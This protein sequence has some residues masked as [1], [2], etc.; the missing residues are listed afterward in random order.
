MGHVSGH[1]SHMVGWHTDCSAQSEWKWKNSEVR[2][3]YMLPSKKPISCFHFTAL[4]KFVVS[5]IYCQSLNF[6]WKNKVTFM[7]IRTSLNPF[8]LFN[9]VLVWSNLCST[10]G[11]SYKEQK[12]GIWS[13]V[14]MEISVSR[15]ENGGN[16]S[17]SLP[18][19]LFLSRP[20][21]HNSLYITSL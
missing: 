12:A 20:Y 3:P 8:N 13:I 14:C 19:R 6:L 15:K 16:I 9:D 5:R 21:K 17:I 2:C 1:Q 18:W 7:E 11:T 4:A 10:W